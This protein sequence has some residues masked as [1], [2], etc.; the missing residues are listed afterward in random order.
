MGNIKLSPKQESFVLSVFEGDTQAEAYKKN[1]NCKN[2]S[3]NAIYREASL[4]LNE[5]RNPKI[6]QRLQELR[7][8]AS[9]K[10][11]WTVERLIK[12]FEE[13]KDKC[14]KEFEVSKYSS[15]IK[16][17]ENIGKLCGHYTEK[18][19][20][21]GEIKMPRVIIKKRDKKEGE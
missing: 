14:M 18:V 17:L 10:S 5:E 1:Y 7:N 13:V 9:E 2:M 19:E 4:L 11:Q 8:E 3:D 16:A 6:A 20:H 12:E 15:V 21:S